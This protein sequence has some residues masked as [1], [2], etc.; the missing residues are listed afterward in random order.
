VLDDFV[1][2]QA[3][4]V[5]KMKATEHLDLEKIIITSPV[6]AAI[7]YSMMDAYRV[8]VVHERRHF[9]QARRVTEEATFPSQG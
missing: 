6:A 5:E 8:I 2:Q 1:D 3:K 7:T 9:E 4:I